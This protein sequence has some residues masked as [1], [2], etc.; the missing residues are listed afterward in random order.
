MKIKTTYNNKTD[1]EIWGKL[2]EGDKEAFE[3][4]FKSYYPVLMG[5]GVKISKDEALT[6]DT[7]QELFCKLW[8][9][10]VKL[11]D[12]RS[13]ESYLLRSMRNNI[14]RALSKDGKLVDIDENQPTEVAQ[15]HEKEMI[16]EEQSESLSKNISL[17]MDKLSGRQREAVY[18][19]YY[20]GLSYEEISEI[21]GLQYQSVRNVIHRAINVL[22]KENLKDKCF[23]IM[24]WV[25]TFPFL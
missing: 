14:I 25:L 13:I 19:K 2:R 11:S 8:N 21:M 6:K 23:M 3:F 1:Q 4:I 10:R 9:N 7:V 18:L 5:Y 15:S 17:A 22:R 12:V 20:K 24:L 16:N